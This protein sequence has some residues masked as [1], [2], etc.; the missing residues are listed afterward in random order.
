MA[1]ITVVISYDLVTPP[2]LHAEFKKEM[3]NRQWKFSYNGKPL[4]NTTCY[5]TFKD[6]ST[7]GGS[8][9]TAESD[10]NKAE[11]EVK[12][13]NAKFK[14]ERFYVVAFPVPPSQVRFKS[15]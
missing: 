2:G 11:A 3:E 9:D 1:Q 14:V 6:G 10:I 13:I 5:A 12:K 4:P 7:E 8:A 15:V